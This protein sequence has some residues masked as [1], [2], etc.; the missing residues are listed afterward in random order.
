M[1]KTETEIIELIKKAKP[2]YSNVIN[3]VME[4]DFA[5]FEKLIQSENI[6][7]SLKVINSLGALKTEKSLIGLE[8]AAKSLNP[9]LRVAAAFALRYF[10]NFPKAVSL[11]S[12]LLDDSDLGS[13]KICIEIRRFCKACY[14]KRKDSPGV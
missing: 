14:S 4:E 9:D 1:P 12:D 11:I 6:N 5:I 8:I 3:L 2:D 7:L 13:K 10:T